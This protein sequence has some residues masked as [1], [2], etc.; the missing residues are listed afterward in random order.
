M[1]PYLVACSRGTF[2][3]FTYSPYFFTNKLGIKNNSI[4][5][6]F[7]FILIGLIC[8]TSRI[9]GTIS[10]FT[11]T[12]MFY[13]HNRFDSLF[14]GVLISHWYHFKHDKLE[15]FVTK[16]KRKLFAIFLLVLVITPI[17]LLIISPLVPTIGF[18]F[19]YLGFGALLLCMLFTDIKKYISNKKM[20][21]RPYHYIGKIGIYS[22]S[23]Y[24]FHGMVSL[25][26]KSLR[27]EYK[28]QDEFA[29]ILYFCLS[30]LV[31][32]IISKLIEFPM[33]KIR[34]KYYSNKPT[35]SPLN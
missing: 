11:M 24:L 17:H 10:N 12:N 19:L 13:S 23:I 25:K 35:Q 14:F 2:L 26:I 30:I 1:E 7:V 15:K 5:F 4:F 27:I 28:L 22:Y 32:V 20:S 29:V 21:L 16:H 8:L 6:L 31:G 3:P 18:T 33:L 9:H 34:D